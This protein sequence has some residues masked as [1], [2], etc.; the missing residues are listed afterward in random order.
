MQQSLDCREY[1]KDF[2]SKFGTEIS[3]NTKIFASNNINLDFI[4]N[5][6]VKKHSID[7]IGVGTVLSTFSDLKPIGIVFKLIDIENKVLMKVTSSI[8]K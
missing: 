3:Q 4:K 2:D 5:M 6:N 1:L 7:G 8:G